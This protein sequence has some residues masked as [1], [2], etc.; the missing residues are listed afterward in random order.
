MEKKYEIHTQRHSNRY[1]LSLNSNYIKDN[2]SPTCISNIS[3]SRSGRFDMTIASLNS[4]K[5]ILLL[6]KLS[7]HTF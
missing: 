7:K 3:P 2:Y 6:I 4:L 5:D 1:G